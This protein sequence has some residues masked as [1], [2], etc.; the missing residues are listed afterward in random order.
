M[1]ALP[2]ADVSGGELDARSIRCLGKSFEAGCRPE[3]EGFE[4]KGGA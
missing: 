2:A 1:V 4:G 3:E